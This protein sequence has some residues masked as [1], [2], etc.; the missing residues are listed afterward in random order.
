MYACT[1]Y[2][3]PCLDWLMSEAPMSYFCCRR[4]ARQARSMAACMSL[5][6]VHG[7]PHCPALRACQDTDEPP[8][9]FAERVT[10]RHSPFGDAVELSGVRPSPIS[11]SS[12]E[13][14]ISSMP[15]DLHRHAAKLLASQQEKVSAPAS[16]FPEYLRSESMGR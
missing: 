13:K 1:S 7:R 4:W 14:E 8:N 15:R 12:D 16:P 11:G 10:R 5:T 6:C 3:L 9:V 2:A